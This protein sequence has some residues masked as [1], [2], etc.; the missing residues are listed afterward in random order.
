MSSLSLEYILT[1]IDQ[2]KYEDVEE[3]KNMVKEEF[4]IFLITYRLFRKYYILARNRTEAIKKFM[5]STYVA[6]IEFHNGRDTCLICA[7]RVDIEDFPDHFK[8]H[9]LF[10]IELS[11]NSIFY[12]HHNII[13]LELKKLEQ[14]ETWNLLKKDDNANYFGI[15]M[16]G[17]DYY[18]KANDIDSFIE[19]VLKR[20]HLMKNIRILDIHRNMFCESKLC[21]YRQVCNRCMENARC[22]VCNLEFKNICKKIYRRTNKN[23][24]LIYNTFYISDHFHQHEN[25]SEDL[26]RDYIKKSHDI[27]KI[28]FLQHNS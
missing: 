6:D 4:H 15:R 9:D 10:E 13:Q 14:Q 11:L 18:F 7:Y 1:L 27:K 8:E 28:D 21:D 22:P 3:F 2:M 24:P 17:N 20:R 25:I 23:K 12:L 16:T 19:I 5:K 26:I